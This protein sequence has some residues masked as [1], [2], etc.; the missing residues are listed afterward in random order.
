MEK[1]L[2]RHNVKTFSACVNS[3]LSLEYAE[4]EN[5][6]NWHRKP[7]LHYFNRTNP[8]AIPDDPRCLIRVG[9]ISDHGACWSNSYLYAGKSNN[10]NK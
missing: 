9:I 7:L 3:I 6:W 10:S 8:R 1:W 5:V 4:Y 2:R